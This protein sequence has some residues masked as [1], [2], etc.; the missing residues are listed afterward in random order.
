VDLL[1][2]APANSTAWPYV[3]GIVLLQDPAPALVDVLVALSA[4][5][6]AQRRVHVHIVASQIQRNEALENNAPPGKCLRQ[7]DQQTGGG[8]PV[9]D[10]VQ[11]RTELCG[12][13]ESTGCVAV[14]GIEETRYT[15]QERACA[16]ME[17]HVVEGGYG[18]D[19]TRVAWDM[20][21]SAESGERR[22]KPIRLGTKRKMFSSGCSFA[23]LV[24]CTAAPLL[25]ALPLARLRTSDI[26]REGCILGV[27]LRYCPNRNQA[28]IQLQI[29]RSF[30]VV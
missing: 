24:G 5:T 27:L 11:Y 17:R 12:L 1:A 7:K 29:P 3:V 16:W 10:H 18:K 4:A 26:A 13:L 8:A 25:L 19:D 30:G 6:H 15:V 28:A 2:S 23:E 22:D 9:R 21:A 20:S 14:E